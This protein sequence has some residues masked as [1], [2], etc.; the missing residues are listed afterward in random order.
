MRA[1]RRPAL[2][3]RRGSFGTGGR[4]HELVYFARRRT[5]LAMHIHRPDP[6]D[7]CNAMIGGIIA[8]F[9]LLAC[10]VIAAKLSLPGGHAEQA[11]HEHVAK[12]R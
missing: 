4:A 1:S 5:T 12:T 2:R 3:R 9:I 8:C 6:T 10:L 11:H 7:D